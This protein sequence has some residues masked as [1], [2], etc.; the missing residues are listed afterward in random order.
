MFVGEVHELF[1]HPL[2]E[3]KLRIKALQFGDGFLELFQLCRIALT[4]RGP[5]VRSRGASSPLIFCTF[6]QSRGSFFM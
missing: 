2:L 6:L 5:D 4:A 3:I 1:G